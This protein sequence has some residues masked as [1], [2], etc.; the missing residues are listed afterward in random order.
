MR[1]AVALAVALI[2]LASLTHAQGRDFSK[3][4]IVPTPLRGGLT[5][6]TGA[7]GNLAVSTGDDGVLVVDDQFAPLA[8]KIHAAIKALTDKPVRFVVNTHYH[9]DHVG[10]NVAMH[11]LGAII[12]AQEN[13]RRRM[14]RDQFNAVFEDTIRATAPAAW[15]VVTFADSLTFHWN[16]QTIRVLHVKPAHTDGDAILHFAE[17]NVVHMGDCFFNGLYPVI[18]VS[19]GGSLEGMIEADDRILAFADAQTQIVPGHGP[20]GDVK[21]LRAFRDMLATVRDRVKPLVRSGKSLQE[22]IAAKP[23]ADLDATWGR[24]FMKPDDWLGVVYMDFT[25]HAAK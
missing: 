12:V 11:D 2:S 7:G 1:R 10:G 9:G 4:E 24:G 6:L 5:M 8:P 18:D 3:V 23:L 19:S 16:G 22:I 21:S 17:A 15:P 14:T 25:R 13:V 20:L